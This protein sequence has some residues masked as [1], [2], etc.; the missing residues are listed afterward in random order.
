MSFA[1]TLG[2]IL[3]A[4]I[5][6]IAKAM[7]HPARVQ[8]IQYFMECKPHTVGEIAAQLA[9]MGIDLAAL[10][11]AYALGPMGPRTRPA[12]WQP[13]ADVYQT[14]EEVI[15][16]L[17]LAGVDPEQVILTLDGNLV[18]VRGMRYDEV[19]APRSEVGHMEIEYGPFEKRIW[20]PWPVRRRGIRYWY[21][22]GMLFIAMQ[23]ARRPVATSISIRVRV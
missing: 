17:E 21:H 4:D 22:R 8:I 1:Q 3:G 6:T 14:D 5:G 7:G 11:R 16:K 20:L 9:A 23:R 12:C 19:P 10:M 2:V 13:A 15:I 18:I